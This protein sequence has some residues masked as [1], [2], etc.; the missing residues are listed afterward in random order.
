M[1]MYAM[2]VEKAFKEAD[3][4]KSGEIDKHELK[5]V[6]NKMSK[7]LDITEITDEEVNLYLNKLDLDKNEKVDQK[8]FGKLFQ[9]I[10]AAKK[11]K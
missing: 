6:L 5:S 2:M 10:I 9:E 1:N 11:K 4:D 8:E 3:K 7:D